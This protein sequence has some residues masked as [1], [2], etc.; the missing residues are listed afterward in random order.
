MHLILLL[1]IFQVYYNCFLVLIA[2]TFIIF[3]IFYLS[4]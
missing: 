3:F 2:S 4:P 1:F